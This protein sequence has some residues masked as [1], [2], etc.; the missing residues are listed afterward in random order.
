[1]LSSMTT[2]WFG[3]AIL[4]AAVALSGCSGQSAQSHE[5]DDCLPRI[6]FH[7]VTYQTNTRV[8]QNAPTGKVEGQGIVL[9][10]DGTSVG[11]ATVRSVVDV[12]TDVAIAVD[13]DYHGVYVAGGVA[14]SSW[15]SQIKADN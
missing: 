7:D 3:G 4:A 8:N 12:G 15:P 14:P 13:G 9:D 5:G 6:R 1:M 11:N 10:C 2:V